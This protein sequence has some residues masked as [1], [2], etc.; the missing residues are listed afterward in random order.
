MHRSHLFAMLALSALTLAAVPVRADVSTEINLRA[1]DFTKD[2]SSS[3][4]DPRVVSDHLE[5]LPGD[6]VG[7]A[8]GDASA[9]LGTGEL[10][11]KAFAEKK[12][13]FEILVGAAARATATDTLTV[14][15]P[16]GGVSPVPVSFQMA[17]DGDLILPDN[18]GGA[19]RAFANVTARLGASND[20]ESAQVQRQRTYDAT[21]AVLTDTQFDNG[22]WDNAVPVGTHFDLPLLILDAMITP[23]TPFDFTSELFV[24]VGNET[25]VT[26]GETAD[27]GNTARITVVLPQGYSLESQSGFFLAGP[28]PEPQTWALFVVGLAGLAYTV[29]R[30]RQLPR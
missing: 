17:V 16:L 7:K 5:R 1:E 3:K 15:D 20:S 9:D 23:G 8:S 30:G 18:G 28:I 6:P 10:R 11:A 19:G 14:V 2:L 26:G 24:S 22:D 13:G 21:G 12:D 27:F 29:R 25:G 4:S